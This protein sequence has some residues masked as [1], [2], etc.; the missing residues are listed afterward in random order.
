MV[1]SRPKE[2]FSDQ[3]DRN[4]RIDRLVKVIIA[5]NYLKSITELEQNE[6]KYMYY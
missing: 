2:S 4:K 1:L 5:P 3:L 6:I